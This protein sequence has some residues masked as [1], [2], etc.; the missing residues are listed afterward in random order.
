M[1][2]VN[3][4]P[5]DDRGGAGITAGRSGGGAFV[6]GGLLAGLALLALL[7]G[8]ADHQISGNRSEVV[9]LTVRAEQAQTRAGELAPYTSFLQMREQRVQAVT[10]LVDSRFDWAQAFQELGRVLPAGKVSLGSIEGTVGSTTAATSASSAAASASSVTSATP[11]GSIPVFKLTGCAVS[12]AEVALMLERL[13]L[14]DGVDEVSLQS[15]TLAA[16]S[17]G[18]SGGCAGG[19]P[20]FTA[21]VTFDALPAIP[22]SGAGAGTGAGTS[23]SSTTVASSTSAASPSGAT[24]TS[25]PASTATTSSTPAATSSTPA[26]TSSTPAA[27]AASASSAGAVR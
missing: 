27:S 9:S 1:R 25:A 2:A 6:I 19:N 17:G 15:S 26:A 3:L 11:P 22:A 20:A 14:I 4:I 18:S 24:A 7:Y 8:L 13:R 10:T 23:T 16:A 21:Q 5:G 12:Q